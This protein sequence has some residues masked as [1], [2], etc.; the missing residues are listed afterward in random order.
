MHVSNHKCIRRL[1]F[2]ALKA[3]KKRNIIAII[4]IA[5]TTLLFTSLFTV[6]MS[7]NAS[8]ETYTFRQ[9]GGYSHGTFKDVT[10]EQIKALQA[11]PDIKKSGTRIVIGTKSEHSKVELRHTNH[12]TCPTKGTR[13][14]NGHRLIKASRRHTKAW[15]KSFSLLH[16]L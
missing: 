2:R 3:A 8:Y 1:S 15:R 5:L 6:M 10:D 16:T 4:A 14:R 11:H 7:V 13:N 9:I 12:R